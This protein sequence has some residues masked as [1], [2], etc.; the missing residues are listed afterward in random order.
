MRRFTDMYTHTAAGTSGI[1]SSNCMCT[2]TRQECKLVI[3]FGVPE[4]AAKGPAKAA[5]LP[6]GRARC[7][8]P[9]QANPREIIGSWASHH[10]RRALRRQAR[11]EPLA[12]V[13][14]QVSA[15]ALGVRG[16]PRQVDP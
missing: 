12:P 16:D 15:A 9:G 1:A 7:A 4:A 14:P 10:A 13:L 3:Q 8:R 6:A 5:P 2:G 11:P